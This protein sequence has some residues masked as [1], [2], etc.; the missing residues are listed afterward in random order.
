MSTAEGH[1]KTWLPSLKR[2]KSPC[3]SRT[4]P[5]SPTTTPAI[6]TLGSVS[7]AALLALCALRNTVVSMIT[8]GI[9]DI[10]QLEK[11]NTQLAYFRSVQRLL[12]R[13]SRQQRLAK[14][15]VATSVR[16]WTLSPT[17]ATLATPTL[18][19]ITQHS[20]RP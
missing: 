13:S 5:P 18:I 11:K 19:S 1:P 9:A 16:L 7:I 2:T 4:V 20:R 12:Q 10:N 14:M 17:N 15:L 3:V 6:P 8:C